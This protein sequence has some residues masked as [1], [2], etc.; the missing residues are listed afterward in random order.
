MEKVRSTLKCTQIILI[1]ITY[2]I[3]VTMGFAS[4]LIHISTISNGRLSPK[5]NI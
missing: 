3:S 1:G 5:D 4:L 2:P